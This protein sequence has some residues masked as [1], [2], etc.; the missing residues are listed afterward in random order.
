VDVVKRHLVEYGLVEPTGL[1]TGQV[2][3]VRELRGKE[4][5]VKKIAKQ[6]NV[7]TTSLR[8]LMNRNGI[9]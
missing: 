9:S 3:L 1:K 8:N 5:A 6:L 4:M 7:P 2:K